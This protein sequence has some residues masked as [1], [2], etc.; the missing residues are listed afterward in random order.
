MEATW[1]TSLEEKN[2]THLK[3]CE[4][5]LEA[6]TEGK[7]GKLQKQNLSL[8]VPGPEQRTRTKSDSPHF[9]QIPTL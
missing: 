1:I 6:I 5:P 7:L 2:P 8:Q 3:N 4:T 9:S